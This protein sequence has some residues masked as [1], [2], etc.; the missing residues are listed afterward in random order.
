LTKE[1]TCNESYSK[2]IEHN[3]HGIQK[4]LATA[5]VLWLKNKDKTSFIT[6]EKTLS[7]HTNLVRIHVGV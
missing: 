5:Q 2:I 7:R 1:N 3:V 6:R 4:F